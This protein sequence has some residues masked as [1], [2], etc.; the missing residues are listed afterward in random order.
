MKLYALQNLIII[1]LPNALNPEKNI[2]NDI[3][4]IYNTITDHGEHSE[5]QYKVT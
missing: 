1:I 4:Y 2:L 3:C 5:M